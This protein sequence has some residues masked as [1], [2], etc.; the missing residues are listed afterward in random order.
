[1][2]GLSHWP[3]VEQVPGPSISS[4][5]KPSRPL[6]AACVLQSFWKGLW[7]VIGGKVTFAFEGSGPAR[8]AGNWACSVWLAGRGV[9]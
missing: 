5:P 2:M 8:S 1:M 9:G 7:K 6:G 4:A 3:G